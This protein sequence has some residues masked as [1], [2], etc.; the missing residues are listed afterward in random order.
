MKK[1]VI[2]F[3]KP[4][5]RKINGYSSGVLGAVFPFEIVSRIDYENNVLEVS[6]PVEIIKRKEVIFLKYSSST[7]FMLKSHIV[8][9]ETKNSP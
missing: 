4:I 6:P 1:L 3:H 5:L 2:Q 8:K 7:L 9:M